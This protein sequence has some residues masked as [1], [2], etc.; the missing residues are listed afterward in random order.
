MDN[1]KR[2]LPGDVGQSLRFARRRRGWSFR[3]AARNLGVSAGYLCHLERGHRV[4][5]TAVAEVLIDGY[6]IDGPRA[7]RL[8]GVAVPDVGRASPWKL[9]RPPLSGQEAG[10]GHGDLRR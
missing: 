6:G 10:R 5:S 7:E 3:V 1:A 9:V 2:H 8:R 4:P